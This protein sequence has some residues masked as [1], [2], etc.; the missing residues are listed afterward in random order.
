MKMRLLLFLFVLFHT[1]FQPQSFAALSTLTMDEAVSTAIKYRPD[2]EAFEKAAEQRRLFAK[3]QI[4]GYFPSIRLDS[5]VS[6]NQ[7]E[8]NPKDITKITANQL[9]Y[10]FSGPIQ[11]YKKAKKEAE[12][13]EYGKEALNNII[14]LEVERAFLDAWLVQEQQQTINALNIST[15]STFE[16][17]KHQ[18]DL[19]LLD[20]NDWLKEAELYAG[21]A[22]T[23]QQY[24]DTIQIVFRRLEFLMGKPLLLAGNGDTTAPQAIAQKHHF[25]TLSWS[26]P[27]KY[28]L[29]KLNHYYDL[30]LKNRPEL[31]RDTKLIE[32]QDAAYDIATGQRLPSVSAFGC[33]GHDGRIAALQTG[34]AAHDNGFHSV[35]V[36]LSWSLLDS[37]QT[38]YQEQ[39]AKVGKLREVLNREK[40]VLDIKQAVNTA[41]FSLSNAMTRLKAEKIRYLRQK[42][43]F[44]LRKQE[45][46]TGLISP[47]TFETA[48]TNWQR[49]Q[50]NWLNVSVD[51]QLRQRDLLFACGYP[52]SI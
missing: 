17:A 24:Y 20:K 26:Q 8:S 52:D 27:R 43:E 13:T 30:A 14:R 10:S 37:L 36:S 46:N 23:I 16:T 11:F 9:I 22:S 7:H 45:L 39:Q 49:A 19:N 44:E 32:A 40:T 6:Q 28:M 1:V 48:Q 21:D 4:A 2:L 29:K 41:Y 18:N 42:N 15:K 25:A 50:L 5:I 34:S 33:A 35:G 31:K 12:S 38:H 3:Q 47:S 51:A